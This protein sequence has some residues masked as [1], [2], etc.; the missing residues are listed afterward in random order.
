VL[1]SRAIVRQLD[2]TE[3]RA[4]LAHEQAHLIRHDPLLKIVLAWAGL[5]ST[6]WAASAAQRSF[7]DAA[8]EAS[9]AQAAEAVGALQVAGSLVSMAR[10][11]QANTPVTCMAFGDCSLERR[12]TALVEGIPRTQPSRS[13]AGAVGMGSA[14]AMAT[15]IGADGIH[16][17]IET[18]LQLF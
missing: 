9:D 11:T 12:I 1:I 7:A 16:H 4:A 2:P 14:A 13:M 5:C 6:P 15:T 8:E 10:L 18:M 17:A 3:V